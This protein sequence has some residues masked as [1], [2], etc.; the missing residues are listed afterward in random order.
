MDDEQEDRSHDQQLQVVQPGLES[1][2]GLLERNLPYVAETMGTLLD[3][4]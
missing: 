2:A 4:K 1:A 3:H